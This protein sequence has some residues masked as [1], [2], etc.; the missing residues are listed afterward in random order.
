MNKNLIIGI[1]VVVVV[2]VGGYFGWK[3]FQAKQNSPEAQAA[4]LQQQ[5]N[6]ILQKVAALTQ[7]PAEEPV[8]FTVND[9][10][11][12]KGQQAF[13]KDA[14]NGDVL[15]VYQQSSKALIFRPST[16]KIINAGPV[17]F[18]QPQATTTPAKK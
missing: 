15:L 12:L 2:V 8:L 9:A 18:Q 11:L 4:Q 16:N 1:V 17:S 10:N 13:F 14:E 6:E 7:V 3:S 5:K